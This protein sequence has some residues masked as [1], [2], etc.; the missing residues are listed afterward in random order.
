MA[1]NFPA[2]PTLNDEVTQGNMVWF[3]N[4]TYWEL[5]SSTS[6]FTAGDDAPSSYTPGDF[7]YETDTGKLYVRFDDYWVE[8]GHSSDGQSFQAQDAAPSSPAA[9]DIWY[10]SDTGKT[11]I[12]YDSYWVEIGHAVDFGTDANVFNL[13]GGESGTNYGGITALN[14]GSSA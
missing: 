11:F 6:K 1:I 12:Y 8:V 7:W 3:W 10:E 4:A 9:N 2:S 5:R 14:G 13:D